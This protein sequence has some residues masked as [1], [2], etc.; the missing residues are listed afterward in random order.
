MLDLLS[1]DALGSGF[2]SALFQIFLN[3]ALFDS[4]SFTDL[5]S[6]E[7]FFSNNLIDVP[8]FAGPNMVQLAFSETMSGSEG[9]SFDYAV[10]SWRERSRPH[11]RC[12]TARPDLGGRW[13]SRLVATAAENRGLGRMAIAKSIG[14]A[15]YAAGFAIWLFGYLSTG[16]ASIFDWDVATPSWISSFVP[17][18]EAEV[19]IALMFASMIPIYWRAGGRISAGCYK[20]THGS[21]TMHRLQHP[22]LATLPCPAAAAR[23]DKARAIPAQAVTENPT[24]SITRVWSSGSTAWSLRATIGHAAALTVMGERFK[25]PDTSPAHRAAQPPRPS[26]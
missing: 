1:N 24:T 6:A 21:P 4:E 9:F 20:C 16:H 10:A 15:I 8:L 26:T 14:W 17:N 7:A 18:L 13:S 2:D 23:Q 12:R 19:G 22:P 11:R 5:A 25:K 3:S